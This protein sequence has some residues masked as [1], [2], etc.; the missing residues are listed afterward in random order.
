MQK[1]EFGEA[2]ETIVGGH[3]AAVIDITNDLID[4]R[5][6]VVDLESDQIAL[7]IIIC[8][9]GEM[10][11]FGKYFDEITESLVVEE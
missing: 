4:I 11:S 7:W 10:T 3:P 8:N 9:E 5:A 6:T 2:T 1:G